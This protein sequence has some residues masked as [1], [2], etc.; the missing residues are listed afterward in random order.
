MGTLNAGMAKAVITPPVG[1]TLCGYAGRN[2]PSTGVF[3]ELY[4]KALVLDDGDPRLAL[5]VC[6]LIGLSKEMVCRMRAAIREHVERIRAEEGRA[7]EAAYTTIRGTVHRLAWPGVLSR[8]GMD[9]RRKSPRT[10]CR[11]VRGRVPS[12]A[13]RS[14]RSGF[15]LRHAR[16]RSRGRGS[17]RR[18]TG[19]GTSISGDT[20]SQGGAGTRTLESM[21]RSAW[22]PASM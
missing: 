8:P 13:L 18:G 19:P 16:E 3:D 9:W 5:V 20:S 11:R 15:V 17:H 4:A 2:E 6:D 22:T 10:D 7:D 12:R 21:S 14:T 1:T